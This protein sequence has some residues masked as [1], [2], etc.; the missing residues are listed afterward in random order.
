VIAAALFTAGRCK[1]VFANSGAG[2]ADDIPFI[3]EHS[4]RGDKSRSLARRGGHR[5]G[6]R[7]GTGRGPR[8]GGWSRELFRR[9]PRLVHAPE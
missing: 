6:H 7:E 1:V 4:D 9:D 8:L 2:I 3:L 5:I